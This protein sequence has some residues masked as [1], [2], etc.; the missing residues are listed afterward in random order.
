[1][2]GP[3]QNSSKALVKHLYCSQIHTSCLIKSVRVCPGRE[4]SQLSWLESSLVWTNEATL[5]C[6]IQDKSEV[7]R[8][9]LERLLNKSYKAKFRSPMT[10]KSHGFLCFSKTKPVEYS[11]VLPQS[12]AFL[13]SQPVYL[14][15]CFISLPLFVTHDGKSTRN[16]SLNPLLQQ[17]PTFISS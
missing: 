11:S 3:I 4:D 16:C 2:D 7:G 17:L 9:K 15:F 6:V 1:M 8:K 10:V 12:P 13:S 5:H 14:L